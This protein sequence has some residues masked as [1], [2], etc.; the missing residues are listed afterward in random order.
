VENW[1][2]KIREFGIPEVE[3]SET[4]TTA[5]FAIFAIFFK[6]FIYSSF[7]YLSVWV[8]LTSLSV[9]SAVSHIITSRT[10]SNQG[11]INQ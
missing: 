11:R 1:K 2:I 4:L 10:D 6:F 3:G 7:H 5:V 8:L 9:E